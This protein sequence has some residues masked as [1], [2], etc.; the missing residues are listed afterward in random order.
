LAAFALYAWIRVENS[1]FIREPRAGFGD[2]REYFLV[3]SQSVFSESFWIAVRP[4]LIPLVYKILWNDLEKI[5][6]FQL[7]FSILSWGILGLAFQRSINNW[8]VRIFSFYLI[9][10]FSLSEEIIMW[11]SLMLSESI[12]ISITILFIASVVNLLNEW[13]L[14]KAILTIVLAFILV[15]TRDAFAYYILFISVV[16][17]VLGPVTGR[18][19]RTFAISAAFVMIFFLSNFFVTTSLR[20]YPSFLN[21]MGYRIFPDADY[22]AYFQQRGMPV[23]DSLLERSGKLQHEDGAAIVTEPEFA[24]FRTWVKDKG[25][26]E[27][28]RFLWFYKADTLQNVFFESKSLLFPDLRYYT[29]TGFRPIVKHPAI[30]ELLYP[31]RFVL[32]MFFAGNLLASGMTVWAYYEK[33]LIWVVPITLVLLTYP[34]IVL[35]WNAD[36]Y[37]VGRHSIH[38]NIQ[39]RLGIYLLIIYILDFVVEK[40][41]VFR[42]SKSG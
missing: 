30:D 14:S 2:T 31:N 41:D 27:Y 4:P 7:W 26:R 21:T 8:L 36:A 38:H 18:Y 35:I 42:F 40:I 39:L 10:A 22:I 6:I 25:R 1:H 32:I 13:S 20:W 34:Q 9:L 37:E 3:A 24:T 23:D 16:I 11:D 5:F 29:S 19:K 33:K 17:L 12:A 15:M 28:L